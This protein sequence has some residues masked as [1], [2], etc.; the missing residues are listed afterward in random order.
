M[1]D[2]GVVEGCRHFPLAVLRISP[3][4]PV[5][6]LANGEIAAGRLWGSTLAVKCAASRRAVNTRLCGSA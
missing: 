1:V 6:P 5:A 4:E 3:P 2:T